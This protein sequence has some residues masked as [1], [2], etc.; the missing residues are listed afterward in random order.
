[1]PKR[2]II[3]LGYKAGHG[4][5]VT[6]TFIRQ[7]YRSRG[8]ELI[9]TI[10][11]ADALKLGI[12]KGV[13]G[14]TDDQL[15]GKGKE[16]LDPFWGFTPRAMLQICGTEAMRQ[17]FREDVWTKALERKILS[18]PLQSFVVADV[19]FPNEA[20]L[21]K[22]LGGLLVR[23]YRPQ[24]PP[25]ADPTHASETALDRYDGW[26]YTLINDS[27]LLDLRRFVGQMLDELHLPAS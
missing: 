9:E 25:C 17:G 11:F 14:L 15:Y 3:G 7:L 6:A 18:Q 2:T 19:R 5:D 13:L 26:D 16:E 12:G 10:H 21:I 20:A 23:V 22:Q 1:M 8:A 27:M 4:K 24:A